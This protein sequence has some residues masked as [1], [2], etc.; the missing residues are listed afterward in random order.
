[1]QSISDRFTIHENEL[2]AGFIDWVVKIKPEFVGNGCLLRWTVT[3]GKGDP[4][5]YAQPIYCKTLEAAFELVNDYKN[6]IGYDELMSK[7][8]ADMDIKLEDGYL[9]PLI[10]KK[11]EYND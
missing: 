8:L 6:Y 3:F 7:I 5:P 10:Y 1:M 11:E 4:G 2:W 9:G